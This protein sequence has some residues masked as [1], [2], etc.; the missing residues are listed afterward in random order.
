M[1]S[2]VIATRNDSYGGKCADVDNF[3]MRRLEVTCFSV[4]QIKAI[5]ELIVVEFAPDKLR[6]I[7]HVRKFPKVRIITITK[8]YH[9]LLKEDSN[10]KLP[11]YEYIAKHV[12]IY[13]AKNEH[14]IVANPDNIF[15][16]RNFLSVID[17]SLKGKVSRAIRY[18]IFREY[19]TRRNN[20]LCYEAEQNTFMTLATSHTAAGDF[21]V[22]TKTLYDKVG[23][24][25]MVHGN[26]H[27]DNDLLERLT[28]KTEVTQI[29][30]H[31]HFDHDNS[32]V[33]DI[34]PKDFE[35][36]KPINLQLVNDMFTYI[37]KVR[38]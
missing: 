10:I 37:E 26:W 21:C 25:K 2:M 4:E 16:N 36:F 23:G 19:C 6:I 27:L 3:T 22:M 20:D 30:E 15:P 14:I 38:T 12:G 9:Q 34:T 35:N 32:R 7:E 29:Y 28:Q 17:S 5:T 11:F 13:S 24:Y 8:K 1:F 18:D 31:Y 33:E